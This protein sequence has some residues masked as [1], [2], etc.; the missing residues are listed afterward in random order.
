MV[1]CV[2]SLQ[3]IE[4]E[5]G[6]G[7]VETVVEIATL[8]LTGVGKEQKFVGLLVIPEVQV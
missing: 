8:W 5:S 4:V 2:L 6:G 7:G 3:V 1:A